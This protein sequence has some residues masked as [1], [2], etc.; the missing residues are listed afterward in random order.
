MKKAYCEPISSMSRCKQ[1][2]VSIKKVVVVKSVK[3]SKIMMFKDNVRKC[4]TMSNL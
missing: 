2:K 4:D 1:T 3:G